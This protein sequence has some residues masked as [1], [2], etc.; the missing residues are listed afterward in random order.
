MQC[1]SLGPTPEC[2][3]IHLVSTG[4][5]TR[6]FT[7]GEYQKSLLS[8]EFVL[9]L[10]YP[11]FDDGGHVQGVVAASLHLDRLNRMATQVQFPP[12]L[13]LPPSTVMELSLLAIR[14]TSWL[15]LSFPNA[16]LVKAMLTQEEGTTQLP[17]VDGVHR[18][19]AF[20]RVH[21][22]S[23]VGLYVSIGIPTEIAFAAAH[24][25]LVRNLITLG[26]ITLLMVT[27][28][29]LGSNA[30]VLRPVNALVKATEQ[31]RSGKLKCTDRPSTRR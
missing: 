14:I 23:D 24:Q 21:D 10:G 3:Q 5:R 1:D 8:N 18:L 30:L 17:G 16:P 12:A 19:Y 29:W 27:A 13:L 4:I 15:G 9:A 6:D 20:S 11:V 25:R 2:G 22:A 26:V 7:V 31:L 28:V